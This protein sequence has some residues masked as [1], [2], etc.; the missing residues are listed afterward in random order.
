MKNLR[1]PAKSATMTA[2]AHPTHQ[3]PG[4]RGT[5]RERR[6]EGRAAAGGVEGS[7]SLESAV[8]VISARR[9][10]S[11][12]GVRCGRAAKPGFGW[13]AHGQP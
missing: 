9:L 7:A 8:V 4:I 3:G 11:E 13:V 12:M 10:G 6:S 2:P 5:K 1:A